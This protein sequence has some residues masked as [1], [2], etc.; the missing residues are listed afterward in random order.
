MHQ[1]HSSISLA[2]LGSCTNQLGMLLRVHIVATK[3]LFEILSQLP[4]RLILW[5]P[6]H[7]GGCLGGCG[8]GGKGG[9]SKERLAPKCVGRGFAIGKTAKTNA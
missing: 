8:R 6:L 2:S 3:G 5:L 4:Q 9:C 1:Q 7:D